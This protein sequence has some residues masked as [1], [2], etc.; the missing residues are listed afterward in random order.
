MGDKA[1]YENWEVEDDDDSGFEV[2]VENVG[3]NRLS[4]VWYYSGNKTVSPR[5]LSKMKKEQELSQ[6]INL[7]YIPDAN[8]AANIFVH[9]FGNQKKKFVFWQSIKQGMKEYDVKQADANGNVKIFSCD[10]W[11]TPSQM[12][13][14]EQFS[15]V[16]VCDTAQIELAYCASVNIHILKQNGN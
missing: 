8:E 6:E 5:T 4:G 9:G 1:S 7:F 12:T 13:D 15:R 10:V 16:T 11:L 14:F 2:F 3:S